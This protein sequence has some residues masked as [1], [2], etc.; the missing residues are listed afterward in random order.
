MKQT[1]ETTLKNSAILA[2]NLRDEL[3]RSHSIA[4]QQG[5]E[6]AEIVLLDLIEQSA[7]L[8]SK[9]NRAVEANKREL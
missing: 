5:R 7:Q 1:L 3:R 9:I 4:I 8:N 6:F 2:S